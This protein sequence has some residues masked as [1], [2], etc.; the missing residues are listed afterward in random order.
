MKTL[1]ITKPDDWHIH[2]RDGI[3]LH[4]TVPDVARWAQRAII[5]PNLSP[6]ICDIHD[7]EAYRHRILTALPKDLF[8]EPLMVLYLTDTTTKQQIAEAALSRHVFGAKLYPAGATTN[9]DSG[10]NDLRQLYP[11]IETMQ[12]YNLPLLIHGE[13]TDI[14]CDIFDREKDFIDNAFVPLAEQFPE[15]RMV[16]EHITT[17]DA[18]EFVSESGKNI[19]ATV[20]AHHLL[21][22]RNDLLAGGVKPHYF[23]LP[24]LKRDS[25][26]QALRKAVTS[27][28]PSFFLGT[29]SAPHSQAE[30]E[31]SCGCAGCYTAH[32]ALELY[33]EVF[34]DESSLDKLEAFASFYG[35]D[36]YELPRN[37]STVTLVKEPKTIPVHLRL[38]AENLI[39][40]RS[41]EIVRWSLRCDD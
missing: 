7:A 2:L 3:A 27:G 12:E 30:K 28:D 8:F 23:C 13:S 11:L 10:I 14:N 25:H 19:A 34:E 9:S 5:M 6:P 1:I 36:F 20:T 15:L 18:V 21:Y 31:S 26:R 29:D 4:T 16:F 24:V 41:G 22:N 38:G 33:A 40:I 37:S 35:P 17:S 39:P 32:C